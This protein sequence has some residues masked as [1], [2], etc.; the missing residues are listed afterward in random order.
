[1]LRTS[2]FTSQMGLFA[3][4][5]LALECRDFFPKTYNGENV[6]DTIAP[7][8]FIRSLSNL[9]ASYAALCGH[10]SAIIFY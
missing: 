7:S 3:L 6:V 8:L 1:M 4:E 2:S 5:L 9:Q 10:D